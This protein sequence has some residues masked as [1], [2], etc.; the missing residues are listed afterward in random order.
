MRGRN[1]VAVFALAAAVLGWF[2]LG[3]QTSIAIER[4]VAAGDPAIEGV[5]NLLAYFT[6]WSNILV[7]VVLTVP[8]LAARPHFSSTVATSIALVAIVYT[9]MLRGLWNPHGAQLV[10]DHLLHDVM[11]LLFLIYWWIAVPKHALRWIDPLRWALF[12]VLYVVYAIARGLLSG[13]YAYPLID[14]GQLGW[15]PVLARAASLVAV[16]VAIGLALV[17]AARLQTRREHRKLMR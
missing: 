17:A 7:A 9:A 12:P 6:I 2:A 13:N 11:P 16:F 4:R 5:W 10:A 3:L 8:R 15:P 14:V 1:G